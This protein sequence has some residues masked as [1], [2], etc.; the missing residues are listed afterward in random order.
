MSKEWHFNPTTGLTSRCDAQIQCRLQSGHFDTKAEAEK[1]YENT[2]TQNLFAVTKR[3][4]PKGL[5]EI[6]AYQ[7]KVLQ[8]AL[9]KGQ[10]ISGVNLAERKKYVADVVQRLTDNKKTTE[11]YYSSVNNLTGQ[12][13]YSDARTVKHTEIVDEILQKARDR[14]VKQEGKAIFSGGLGGAGKT[15]VLNGHVGIDND[16]Y[17]VVNP[18]DIKEIMAER[19]MIP[20]VKGLTPME[21]SPLVHEESSHISSV[22]LRKVTNERMNIIVDITMSNVGSVESRVDTLR[23]NNYSDID[24]VFVDIK[25]ETSKA[26]ADARYTFGMNDYTEKGKGHGGRHLPESVIDGNA[27]TSPNFN[28]RN[29][30][31]L[32]ALRNLGVFTS[33]PLIFN[34]DGAGPVPVPYDEFSGNYESLIEI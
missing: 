28:S 31:N 4:K 14:G 27:T 25:L 3:V 22:L 5:S 8:E 16:A 11:D 24:V 12:R 20:K 33:K 2:Q 1:A 10:N 15:T 18:D 29:A 17:I 34:N 7:E 32:V 13:V 9:K 19:G 21:A 30:E 23:K 6:A 26:R